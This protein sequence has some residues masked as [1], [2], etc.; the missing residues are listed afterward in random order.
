MDVIYER[1]INKKEKRCNKLDSKTKME[2]STE[3]HTDER[4][5][6]EHRLGLNMTQ[7]V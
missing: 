5:T 6:G 4:L 3:R 1:R 7:K 2:S